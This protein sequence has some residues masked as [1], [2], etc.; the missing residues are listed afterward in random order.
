MVKWATGW[1]SWVGGG[2][3]EGRATVKL[4]SQP[5]AGSQ[6]AS[7]SMPGA[8][9]RIWRMPSLGVRG[10]GHVRALSAQITSRSR[11]DYRAAFIIY[12][13]QNDPRALT[14]PKNKKKTEEQKKKSV[15]N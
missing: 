3:M 14:R 13:G 11:R 1:P 8:G 12:H 7:P 15:G 6:L 2:W 4:S 9:C 10:S 5:G